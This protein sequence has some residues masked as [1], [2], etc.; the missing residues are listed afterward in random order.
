MKRDERFRFFLI[1]VIVVCTILLIFENVTIHG[2]VTGGD[3]VS[4]VS[5]NMHLAI[6]FSQELK[7]GV[8]FDDVLILPVSDLNAIENYNGSNNST[9]YHILVSSDGNVPVDLCTRVDSPLSTSGMD[10]IGVAN[11]SYSN[12]NFTNESLPEL[13]DEKSF[14]LNFQSAGDSI[15]V[16]GIEYFRF[17]LDIPAGQPPGEYSNYIIFRA[18]PEG[19]NC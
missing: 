7:D 19:L 4:N 2:N 1:A 14:S 17:W 18:I 3:V 8:I 12:F 13:Q 15:P 16:G 6:D 10:V 9:N 5:V 11:E